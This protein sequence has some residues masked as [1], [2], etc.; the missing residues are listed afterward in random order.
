MIGAFIFWKVCNKTAQKL[1]EA[2][3]MQTLA[4][5]EWERS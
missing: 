1:L 3:V 4:E 2:Y 5:M